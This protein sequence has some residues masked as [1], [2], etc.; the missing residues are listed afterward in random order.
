MSYDVATLFTSI[1]V[2][3]AMEVIKKNWNRIQSSTR[4]PPHPSKTSW[5]C[6][7]FAYAILISY[8][9]ANT[10]NKPRGQLWDLL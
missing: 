4:E 3:P 2:K 7:S 5:T 6:W 10:M 1:P 9:R 8:S